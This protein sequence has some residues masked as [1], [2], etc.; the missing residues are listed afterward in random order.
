VVELRAWG[1]LPAWH[2][3]PA[4]PGAPAALSHPEPTPHEARSIEAMCLGAGPREVSS[5]L[6]G[7]G[8]GGLTP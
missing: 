4:R 2:S 8:V 3:P 5:H 1:L 7:M 6:R